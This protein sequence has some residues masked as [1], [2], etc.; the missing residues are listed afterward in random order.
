MLGHL[1][2]EQHQRRSGGPPAARSRTSAG[3]AVGGLVHAARPS[4]RAARAPGRAARGDCRP[5]R[6]R[7]RPRSAVR[8]RSARAAPSTAAPSATVNQNVL[9]RPGS[10]S[11][12]IAPP[13][14]SDE[15]LGDRQAEARA[16]VAARGR[17]S[18][19]EKDWNS[20]ACASGA[21]PMPVSATSKRSRTP[22]SSAG[23]APHPHRRPRPR[24]VNLMALPTRL[25]STCRSRPD[26]PARPPARR[27]RSRT[28]ARAPCLRA[29]GQQLEAVLDVVARS[30]SIGLE[31]RA[32]P[33]RSSR[34][35]GCR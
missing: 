10:L 30:N 26:R 16:A 29:L 13:I 6:A 7:W 35:R 5:P 2:V 20:R 12:P 1:H 31:L 15:L 11:T 24:S 3:R 25:I 33:P 9:P 32:C 34:S 4:R 19:C 18:A 28:P 14:S 21:M 23:L 27:G 17:A 8:R 22:P